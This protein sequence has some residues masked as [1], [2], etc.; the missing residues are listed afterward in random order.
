MLLKERKA[1]LKW[2]PSNR[3]RYEELGYK[4]TYWK[5][6]FKVDI[7]HLTDT[8][9]AI[10]FA[11]CDYCKDIK[12]ITYKAYNH[13]LKRSVTKA[14]CCE[15]IECVQ[16]KMRDSSLKLYGTESAN[17]SN[18]VKK[19]KIKSLQNKYGKNYT[20]PSQIP[21]VRLKISKTNLAKY[22]HINVLA[23][24]IYKP[25][26]SGSNNYGWKGGIT[27]ISNYCRGKITPW[28]KESLNSNN[29]R[30]VLT[31]LSERIDVH[32]KYSFNKI[33]DETFKELNLDVR[34]DV[35]MYSDEELN[36]LSKR[37][38]KNNN[39]YGLGVCLHE[40][41]HSLYHSIYSKHDNTPEQFDEFTI[42][43]KNG[44]FDNH[45]S[46]KTK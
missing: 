30:C 41:I 25:L 21:E 23:S 31:G 22:G 9:R 29:Y 19:N 6:E 16:K 34:E 44:D 12:E 43:F 10:V 28:I 15:K 27:K 2:N 45:L 35:S 38:V 40:E 32:H 13:N 36:A 4:F 17:Q 46:L 1:I 26:Y 5:D 18:I 39:K 3:K 8:S 33:L 11:Q 24:E 14:D 20:N 7:S 42:R 37:I